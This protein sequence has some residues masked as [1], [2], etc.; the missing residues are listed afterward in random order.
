MPKQ[1]NLSSVKSPPDAIDQNDKN[2][3][4][5]KTNNKVC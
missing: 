5:A 3:T 2:T 1:Q 4:I